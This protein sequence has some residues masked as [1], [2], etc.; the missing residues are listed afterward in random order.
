MVYYII[1]KLK[2]FLN[3]LE[4]FKY[5]QSSVLIYEIS[6]HFLYFLILL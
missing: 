6:K 2:K 5:L 4:W 3:L 1:Y